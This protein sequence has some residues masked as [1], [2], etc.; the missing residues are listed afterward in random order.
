MSINRKAQ[1]PRLLLMLLALALVPG[2][3]KAAEAGFDTDSDS[4]TDTHGHVD[5]DVDSDSDTDVDPDSR[6][7]CDEQDIP[8]AHVPNR[9]MLLQ[10]RSASMLGS[11]WNQAKNAIQGLLDTF[12]DDAIEFGL[13]YFP[14]AQSPNCSSWQP[15]VLDSAPGQQEAIID[16]LDAIEPTPTTPLYCALDNFNE[17]AYAPVFSSDELDHFLVLIADGEDSCSTD[18]D[19]GIGGMVD[20]DL[21]AETTAQLVDNGTK[22]IVIGFLAPWNAAQ[23]T[24]IAQNGGTEFTDYLIATDEASLEDALSSIA[25]SV[26]SCVFDVDEPDAT[27][28]P[29]L[30]NFYFD[31]EIVFHVDDCEDGDGWTWH[32]E[33]HTQVEFCGDSCKQ[34]KSED[35]GSI[36]ATFGCASVE[37]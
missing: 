2:C 25:Y 35:V 22:V 16:E 11:N 20:V 31:G 26:Y 13:D 33:D 21:L 17:P 34:L 32:D 15:V 7:I 29:D 12:D 5:T 9:L 10:D 1:S 3:Y 19:G 36:T 4:E 23:L 37:E 30:V 27:A 6:T 14:D 24:A 28:D 18:C 8:I